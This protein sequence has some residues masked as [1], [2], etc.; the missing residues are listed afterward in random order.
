MNI[1]YFEI[2]LNLTAAHE[3]YPFFTHRNNESD[4]S[5]KEYLFSLTSKLQTF[6]ALT[7]LVGRQEGHP[8]TTTT[9]TV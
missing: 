6:S 4:K 3:F 1:Q 7:L 8:A 5:G 9:T 2:M